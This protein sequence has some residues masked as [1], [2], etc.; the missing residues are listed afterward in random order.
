[1]SRSQ[2]GI[3]VRTNA[4]HDQ[5]RIVPKTSGCYVRFEVVYTRRKKNLNCSIILFSCISRYWSKQSCRAL[6][7]HI[8]GPYYTNIFNV[9]DGHIFLLSYRYYRLR[10]IQAITGYQGSPGSLLAKNIN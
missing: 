6:V 7:T 1:M 9:I 4:E 5:V 3:E 8:A 10:R 2:L